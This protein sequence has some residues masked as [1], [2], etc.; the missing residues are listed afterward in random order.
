MRRIEQVFD[1]GVVT[2]ELA[3]VTDDPTP[4]LDALIER[5]RPTV[6][7]GERT[8]P[9]PEVLAGLFPLGGLARG[10]RLALRGTGAASVCMATLAG[11]SREGSWIAVVGVGAW[12]WSA[13][14]RA[15]WSLERSVFVSEPPTSQWGAVVAA[16]VDAVDVVVV[17]P[18]HQVTATDA[19]RLA[20]RSR[21]RGAVVVDVALDDGRRRFRWPTE[22]DLTM[23]V[24]PVSWSGLEPG[25]GILSDRV[26]R[27]SAEG[28]RGA[29]RV[30]RAEIAIDA[31]G[32][33]TARTAPVRAHLRSVS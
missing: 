13:A 27:L 12:G 29:A 28:R 14:A 17:D 11:A 31:T 16:L 23:T 10:T 15:G 7:S 2:E 19:R 5:L 20:A 8:L 21:E 33:L 9:V 18:C 3:G 22:A 1:T 25:H 24:E 32:S 30:R 26:L 4:A 6:L